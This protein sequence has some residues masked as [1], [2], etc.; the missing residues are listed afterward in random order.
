MDALT[1]FAIIVIG[2]ILLGMAS[3]CW[4]ADSRESF[5]GDHLR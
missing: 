2:L 5:A 4:G 1:T 3:L